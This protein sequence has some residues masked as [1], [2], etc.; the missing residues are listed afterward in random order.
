MVLMDLEGVLNLANEIMEE[1]PDTL[2]DETGYVLHLGDSYAI[3][4]EVAVEILTHYPELANR[5]KVDEI[6][7]AAGLHDIG[8]PFAANQLFHDLRGAQYIE[9]HGLELG[10]ADSIEDVYRIVQMFRPHMVVYEQFIDEENADQRGEFKD[11]DPDL[12]LPHKWQ[13]KIVVYSDASNVKGERIHFRERIEEAL[14]R[15]N[16]SEAYRSMNP[17]LVRAL[18]KGLPRVLKTCEL[19]QQLREGKLSEQEIVRYG[20]I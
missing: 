15:Y 20:F 1:N 18:E 10:V 8:R 3:A 12:L 14:S 17:S 13:Q 2:I 4:E 7:L 11:L 16:N 9:E 5:L 6:A 19:V